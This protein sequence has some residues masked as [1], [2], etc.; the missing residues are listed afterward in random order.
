M[1]IRTHRLAEVSEA[2]THRHVQCVAGSRCFG[3]FYPATNAFPSA[4]RRL[5]DPEQANPYVA[6]PLLF[7]LV[8]LV[9]ASLSSLRSL[10]A[11][12][13]LV[14]T[15]PASD[16]LCPLLLR[17]AA[18]ISV[19]A[20]EIADASKLNAKSSPREREQEMRPVPLKRRRLAKIPE[21]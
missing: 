12:A 1:N 21:N 4:E 15:L 3:S 10:P 20:A 7:I 14:E 11:S 9:R 13:Q 6:I 5:H 17:A 2:P 19:H 16:V 8:R 18:A